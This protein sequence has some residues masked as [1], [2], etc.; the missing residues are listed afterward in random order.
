[1]RSKAVKKKQK[2]KRASQSSVFFLPLAAIALAAPPDSSTVCRRRLHASLIRA[3]SG[4]AVTLESRNDRGPPLPPPLLELSLF[5]EESAPAR[6]E[7]DAKADSA[8]VDVEAIEGAGIA[9]TRSSAPFLRRSAS[10]QDKE[11]PA[12]APWREKTGFEKK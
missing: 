8:E 7:V 10:A 9:A 12:A 11:G 2:E 6:E 3:P 4:K 1:M 5:G